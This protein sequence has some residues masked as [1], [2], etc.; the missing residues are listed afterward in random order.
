MT[1]TSSFGPWRPASPGSAWARPTGFVL[2]CTN[3]FPTV[4][5]LARPRRQ[6]SA[7]SPS[8]RN[9]RRRRGA[10][11]DEDV[12]QLAR[13]SSRTLYISRRGCTW[14]LA[15]PGRTTMA[16][17][18]APWRASIECQECVCVRAGAHARASA[19]ARARPPPPCVAA[20]QARPAAP[21]ANIAARQG[22][23]T[24]PGP[25]TRAAAAAAPSLYVCAHVS[26]DLLWHTH[27]CPGVGVFSHGR[28]KRFFFFFLPI[29]ALLFFSCSVCV[30]LC[31]WRS[32]AA[33]HHTRTHLCDP[34][35]HNCCVHTQLQA[36]SLY[37]KPRCEEILLQL[38]TSQIPVISPQC[39]CASSPRQG[40]A[41]KSCGGD[42]AASDWM[43]LNCVM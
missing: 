19:R 28:G 24:R 10:D 3:V 25:H 41:I 22:R 36:L 43:T 30:L 35:P 15:T 18:D 11:A 5:D 31:G 1:R 23:A 13:P 20:K 2:R 37:P 38:A 12:L 21:Y 33:L 7:E 17:R 29:S 32:A 14:V 40:P 26:D 9:G 16:A 34:C 39:T 6:L 42:A 8:P 27:T 4:V